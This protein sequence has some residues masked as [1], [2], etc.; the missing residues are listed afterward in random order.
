MAEESEVLA[1]LAGRIQ[2]AVEEIE[3]LRSENE[4]L[5]ESLKVLWAK[6]SD[7]AAGTSVVFDGDREE[8]K[9]KLRNYIEIIDRHLAITEG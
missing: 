2:E 1:R 6:T 5:T 3:R 9:E 4:Q 7:A 8:L